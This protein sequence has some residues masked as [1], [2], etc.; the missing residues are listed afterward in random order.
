MSSDE[1]V[2][3]PEEIAIVGMAGRFP[4][5]KNIDEF[6]QNLRDGV[7]SIR[8]F[9]IEELKISGVDKDTLKDPSFVN[10][11]AVMDEADA[12]DAKFF[13]ISA[14]E[15]EIMDPQHRVFLE[16][17][18]E[19]L[20][21]S[22]YDPEKYDGAIGVFGGVAP[23]TYYQKNLVT[24]SDLLQMVG[25]YAAMIA[26]EREYAIT[27]VSFKMNLTGPSI[28]INTACSSS[29]VAIHLACQSVLS[30]ECD[31]ALAG[32]ARIKAPLKSGYLYQEDG[33]PSPDGHCRAFDAEAR[34]TVIGSGVAMIVVKRLSEAIA[35]GDTIHAVIK[36]SAINND[37]ALKV[38][39]TAPSMQGQAAVIAEAQAMAGV[40]ADNIGYV[41][42]HGTGTSLGD[43]IEVAALTK[44]FRESSSRKG[45]CPIGSVKTNIGHLDAGAG[46][47]GVIKTVL[48]LKHK[49]LPPSLNYKKPNPQIDFENSPFY[50]NNKFSEWQSGDMPRLAGVSSFGL[51]GTN[52]HIILEEA[53]E[54][55]PSGP[56]RP[57]QLL[58]LSGKTKPA[59]DAATI[60]LREY[61]A[62]HSEINIAD[63]SYTLQTGRKGHSH[64]GIAVCKDVQDAAEV[65]ESLSPKHVKTRYLESGEPPVVFMFP[66][67]AAQ[68][69]NM[70]LNFYEHEP[71]FREEVDRCA[72]ILEPLMDR[73]LRGILYPK[74]G[75]VKEA[76]ELL[77]K[78]CYLQPAIFTIEYALAKLWNSWGVHASA[79]IGHSIAEYTAACLAGVFSIESALMLVSTRGRMM[80]ELP[81]G[82][83][84]IVRT[85]VEEIE[86]KLCQELSIAAVN[87]PSLCVISGN[88]DAIAALKKKL[89][90]E[91]IVCRI[92]NTSHAFHSPMM[93]P[94]IEPF[95][96]Y[97]KGVQLSPPNIPLMSTV[98]SDWMTPEQATDPVYWGRHLRATV[99]F[100]GGVRELWKETERILLEVGPRTTLTTLARQQAEDINKQLA[101]SS[102]GDSASDQAEWTAI[103]NAVGQLWL[104]GVP[105]DWKGFY[106]NENRHRVP[107]PTYPFERKRFWVEP[108]KLSAQVNIEERPVEP[109][110]IEEEDGTKPPVSK[111]EESRRE[112][113][114][115]I[116]KQT[117][118]EVSGMDLNS[119][120]DSMTFLEMGFDSL[121]LTQWTFMLKKKFGI[122][123]SFHHLFDDLST[124]S[125]LIEYIEKEMPPETIS[126]PDLD[127]KK[128]IA[129][130]TE[131][132]KTIMQQESV[133]VKEPDRPLETIPVETAERTVASSVFRVP[134]L[135]PVQ[136]H[137][138][139]PL[140]FGQQR[141][142]YLDKLEPNTPVYNLPDAYRLKGKL[143]ITA[144]E[145]SI[146]E[147]LR[148][149]EVLR[150]YYK[151]DDD[152]PVQVIA[153]LLEIKLSLIDLSDLNAAKC[154]KEL[155]RILENEAGKPF[156]LSAGPLVRAKLIRLGEEEHVFFFM[157]HHSVFDGWSF[158]VFQRELISIYKSIVSG[159]PS[160]LVELKVQYADY[161]VWQRKWLQ[162]EELERQVAYWREQLSGELPVLQM[163]TDFTRP[164]MQSTR[165]AR[166][167]MEISRPLVESLTKLGRNEGATLYMVL[168]AAFKVFLYR[169]TGQ[170]DLY[171]GSPIANRMPQETEDLIGFFVNTLVLRTSLHGNPTFRELLDR[172]RA[173]CLGAYSH[174]IMPFELLVEELNPQRDLSR[175]PLY[176][177]MFTFLTGSMDFGIKM[178]DV[179]WRR[180]KI[181]TSVAQTD[182]SIWI[183]KTDEGLSVEL[184]YCTDLFEAETIVKLLKHYEVILKGIAEDPDTSIAGFSILSEAEHKQLAKWNDT[185]IGYPRD[186]CV[187][188]LFEA[189]VERR[190]GTV[191]VECGK[192][193]IT[194]RE[195]NQRANKL[196]HYLQAQGV[197]P[198]VLVGICIER[199]VDMLVG[200]LGILKAGGAYVPLDPEYPEERLA[201]MLEDSRVQV[202]LTQ[203]AHKGKLSQSEVK[204]INMD[205]DWKII[206]RMQG[207]N[208]PSRTSPQNL[209]YVIFTS[210]STGK[211]KGVQVPHRAVVNFLTSMSREPGMTEE[212]VLLA[213]TTLSFDIA[214]LELF[215]P[216]IVGAKTIIIS[217]DVASNGERLLGVL[218][219]SGVTVMQATPT[220]WRLLLAAGW[221]G[222]D[223]LKVLCGGEAFPRDLVQECIARS[224]SVWNM[225]GPTETTIWSTCCQLTE[226]EWPVPIGKP[227][228]NTQ[229]YILDNCMQPLPVG[230]A[231][232]LYIGGD[233]VTRGY[234]NRPELTK[235]RFIQDPFSDDPE[236]RLY[237]TGDLAR[238]FKDGTVEWLGRTDFQ[239]KVRGFR[240]ELGEIEVMLNRN[241][242]VRE[243]V[244]VA[245]EDVPGDIRLV[246]YFV[247]KEE[248]IS[249]VSE[250]RN[251]LK[252]K[253]PDYM[254]PLSWVKLE[255]FP[256]TLNGK[257]NRK[258]LLKPDIV[259]TETGYVAP[260]DQ[261]EL[262]LTSIWQ[263]VL[264]VK[265]IGIKDNF[266]ELG[267]H[268][269]LA[270][271]LFAQIEKIIG[272]N[273]PLAALFKTPTIEQIA[274]NLRQKDWRP[275]WSS[276]VMIQT[277]GSR[278]PLFLIHG[279]E[280]NVLIYRELSHY[281]GN[282]QPVYGLQSEGLDGR[283]NLETSFETMAENY[284]RE[285]RSIQP[286]G[287]YYLGGYCLGG[288]I[289]YEMALQLNEQ[290]QKVNLL[291]MFETYNIKSND[292]P[293]PKFYKFYHKIQ[294]IKFH[295][296]N[297]LSVKP[298]DRL[299]FIIDKSRVAKSR[300]KVRMDVGISKI[301]HKIS[302]NNGRKY[303][304][305]L[306]DKVNDQA[307]FEYLPKVYRGSVTLFRPKKN[308]AGLNDPEFGWRGMAEKGVDIHILQM[309][310][311]GMMVEPFVKILA[312]KL[313]ECLYAVSKT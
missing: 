275:T 251:Y 35:D 72:E 77:Q 272:K 19:A 183:D 6:W 45:F 52:A 169:Y 281:L 71:V 247:P 274:Q 37:G 69:V 158:G 107:L 118:Q 230:V 148:R 191:A 152:M 162:G 124:I 81:G 276:L 157:P 49:Q 76:E 11:G 189:Q 25:H 109:I 125:L 223:K 285:I 286:E 136:R 42:A 298:R 62:Q 94:M 44:A 106:I 58:L 131:K 98:T 166:E 115:R 229:I 102:L 9:T 144:L 140:S 254:V 216:L 108:A 141:L 175:S 208:P 225:Y 104:A 187:H 290:N 240:I 63:V 161:A 99:R 139:I 132:G 31:M 185:D 24:R 86:P 200:L 4:G 181:V 84:L 304:H 167:K 146:N 203:R 59:I 160:K 46:A 303:H 224:A 253:L 159:Q 57:R 142:W 262:Q 307:M 197:G 103:L 123:I 269:L 202:L 155:T 119:V 219:T 21:H 306:V 22:G 154:E 278:P 177:V 227:I 243:A 73:D 198:K 120:D 90:S 265:N 209:A 206:D 176:Q 284:I 263:R 20:E 267:G 164:A 56:S 282:D 88:N 105:V 305:L 163:P 313:K 180:E 80:Q 110:S 3:K 196:A 205:S 242:A 151:L 238:F 233:G 134:K 29:A 122:Q 170:E 13:G 32:G 64:R 147:I 165:G 302:P 252:E 87:A 182:L 79:M 235:E 111:T 27:R 193:R 18:W 153:P 33:I 14:R 82:S 15:A 8:P 40:N 246:A 114:I 249:L 277:C 273:I 91:K 143:D 301:I 92:L 308:F 83:M 255:E 23:N 75:D 85:T 12:F 296:D 310:P 264:G 41:E 26:S 237:R 210:G 47:A 295:L 116:L 244:V 293:L 234:L 256:L 292:N 129:S 245:R 138:N 271:R 291:A 61:L 270:A 288:T 294:D 38:G 74:E 312:D 173:V 67:Q 192:D 211:P 28:S 300:F 215:L 121:F 17:A 68:Y 248:K 213:V 70:G 53:P 130:P 145:N 228:A 156:D 128:L 217:R 268:S 194:Y 150:T 311:K 214:G 186:S 260:R 179:S 101:V 149:H 34:G 60:N 135:E 95:T 199:S 239:V 55:Q 261:L 112:R 78:T 89:E 66:G 50:V 43:P 126:V 172:I 113:L 257:I 97:V 241:P 133:P 51:G 184:E 280:G 221:E 259:E 137:G 96:E 222:S 218:K 117:L 16:C 283:E 258:A 93:D 207:N 188:H 174:Q 266:F 309:N 279:A 201:Y 289:A 30:G 204:V 39:F 178:G 236:S 231:G 2:N 48:A 5:A 100:A 226:N 297:M 287:P 195:L 1:L 190:A 250:L 299:K 36:G 54:I 7:E 168:L 171:V 212:D 220:T 232:E 65:L 127:K 10:A